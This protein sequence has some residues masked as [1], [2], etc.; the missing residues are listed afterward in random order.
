MT[1]NA[2]LKQIMDNKP[3]L[4]YWD[5]DWQY[6]GFDD[7]HLLKL[8][9]IAFESEVKASCIL[10]TGAGL[11]TLVF[12]SGNPDKLIS[13]APDKQ[14]FERICTQIDFF[15]LDRSVHDIYTELSEDMLPKLAD[16]NNQYLDVALIDGGHGYPTVFVDFCF[17]NKILKQGG[18]LAVDDIQLRAV[19]ELYKLLRAQSDYRHICNVGKLAI[20]K[21]MTA[22]RHFPDFGS[23]P[24]L[25]NMADTPYSLRSFIKRYL[26][27]RK[28]I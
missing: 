16:S 8:Y 14:L 18:I 2:I 26:F 21:K 23:Q 9:D 5:G 28:R 6:G 12:L 13:I 27:L 24:Y 17:I 11:S 20:F 15:H 25:S 19:R 4:H 7:N 10:E 3:K 22:I 1:G